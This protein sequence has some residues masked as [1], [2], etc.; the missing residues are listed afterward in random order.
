MIRN[1][2]VSGVP[3][4]LF[5]PNAFEPES[6]ITDLR[7]FKLRGTGMAV[8]SIRIFNKWGEVVWQSSLLDENGAPKESWN[9][10]MKGQPAPQGVYSWDVYARF[11]DG[12]EWK[13]M[14]YGSGP[15]KTTGPVHLIR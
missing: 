11:L 2:T 3:G 14:K 6:N 13:G 1:V 8:F 10:T 7:S 12:N 5:V 4:F 9:G 15:G